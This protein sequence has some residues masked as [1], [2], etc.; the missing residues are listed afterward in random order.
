[1]NRK[2]QIVSL[3]VLVLGIAFLAACQPEEVVGP[4]NNALAPAPV[5]NDSPYSM[6]D[7]IQFQDRLWQ[8]N[9]AQSQ[10]PA[11]ATGLT[12]TDR[13]RFQ[14]QLNDPAPASSSPTLTM[15]ERI[16][17]QDQRAEE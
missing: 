16:Q 2:L 6:A 5:V 7:R 10:A 1:M 4:A 11:T 3:I 9:S 17:F 15:A 13:I 12:M 8:Q 14:D